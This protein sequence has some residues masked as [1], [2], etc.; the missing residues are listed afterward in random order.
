MAVEPKSI[1]GNVELTVLTMIRMITARSLILI[2]P[3]ELITRESVFQ[4]LLD[5]RSRLNSW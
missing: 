2:E 1:G 4:V 3:L 5:L